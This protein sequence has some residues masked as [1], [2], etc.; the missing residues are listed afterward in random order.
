MIDG[1]LAA[2][3]PLGLVLNAA[4]GW[5]CADPAAG[6]VLVFSAA[7]EVRE[8][9]VDACAAAGP[10]RPGDG[11]AALA[12]AAAGAAAPSVAIIMPAPISAAIR[13]L[14]GMSPP[15]L[16]PAPIAPAKRA[17]HTRPGPTRPL[18]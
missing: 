16:G 9:F 14:I 13:C 17:Q 15:Q 2:V 12:L 10:V 5:W 7:R 3:V 11:L 8:I 4:L 1:I 6:Y 18:R